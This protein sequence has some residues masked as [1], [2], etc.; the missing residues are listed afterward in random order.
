MFVACS[1]SGCEKPSRA[2]GW[3]NM[4]YARWFRRNG[5]LKSRSLPGGRPALPSGT[6]SMRAVITRYKNHARSRDLVFDLTEKECEA[7]FDEP[8][9]Y[10]GIEPSNISSHPNRNGDF[11]YNGIDR[12]DNLQGYTAI[13]VVTCCKQCN[14]AKRDMDLDEFLDWARRITVNQLHTTRMGLGES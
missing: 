14:Y 1:I 10:C 5:P 4:H 8:C 6:A 12:V 9:Q 13:N 7:L 11:V 2:R 3:C